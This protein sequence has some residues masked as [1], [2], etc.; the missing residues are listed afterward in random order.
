MLFLIT[1]VSSGLGAALAKAALA[2]GH[3]VAGTIRRAADGEAFASLAPGRSHAVPLDVT[4]IPA[5][6]PAIDR[7]VQSVGAI[8]VL[9]NNAGYGFEGLVE[10]SSLEQLRHQFEVNFF[11]AV[12]VTKAVLPH[13]RARRSGR[14]INITSVGGLITHPGTSF[15]H[16]S[17]FAL[18]G[19]SESLGKEVNPFGIHVTAIEPGGFRTDW[20]GRSMIRGARSIPDYDAIFE[21][22]RAARRAR[23]GR[24]IGDPA[25][26]AQVILDVVGMTDPPANLILGSDGLT[27]MRA[28]LTAFTQAMEAWEPVTLA[29][30]FAP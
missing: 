6:Q 4:D 3:S 2:A 17:K 19:F 11:G 15:Y 22:I 16:A 20:A 10:E 25:K 28:K 18:E 27:W 9:V 12:A 1:G 13:M 23:D 24:Q 7:I 29:T 26:G 5:I 21:P 30:D 14:I 8:D